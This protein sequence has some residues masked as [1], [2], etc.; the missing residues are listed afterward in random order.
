MTKLSRYLLFII[1]TPI[2]F[3]F[4][5][6]VSVF[7]H[8]FAHATTAWLYGF[9]LSPFDIY[10]GHFDWR[11]IVFTSGIDEHVNYYLIDMLGHHQLVGLIAFA[12]PGIATLG[13]YLLSF[14]LLK[15][16]KVK[17]HPYLFYFLCWLNLLNLSE[18]ISYVILRSFSAHG[19]IGHIVFSWG[20]SPWI[21]FLGGGVLL[22]IALWYFFSHTLPE[23]YVRMHLDALAMKVLLLLIFTFI[24]FGQG[25]IRMFL[26]S[27]GLLASTLGVIF[28]LMMPVLIIIC[29]PARQWVKQ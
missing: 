19:D 23:L 22:V 25:G 10:Y 29:W 5:M 9:K 11:N 14:F 28:L 21:I 3:I 7:P 2:F 15:W 18:L 24:V 1:I 4:A 13:I 20:I 26:E 17:N 12:G 6:W 16:Q 8:E 27:Y